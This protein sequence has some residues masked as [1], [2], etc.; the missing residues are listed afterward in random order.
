VLGR[1]WE[2]QVEAE[3]LSD[4]GAPA[5]R[6]VALAEARQADLIVVGTHEHGFL[7]RLLEASVSEDVS[8]ATHCDVMLVH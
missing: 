5:E 8:R 1:C 2:S 3:F 4:A 7:A 6:I